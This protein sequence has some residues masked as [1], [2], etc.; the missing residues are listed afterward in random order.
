MAGSFGYEKEHYDVSMKIGEMVL[1][2]AVCEAEN[3]VLIVARVPVAAT[4]SKMGQE[5]QHCT[6]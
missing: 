3:N 1:F 6:R 2:P 5:K 4:R